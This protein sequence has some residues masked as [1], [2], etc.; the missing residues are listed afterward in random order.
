[1][2]E[3]NHYVPILKWKKGEQGAI[4]ELDPDIKNGLTPL[5]E[6][7]PIDWDYENEQPKRTIDEHLE[8]LLTVLKELWEQKEC[9]TL[10]CYG[11]TLLKE[12]LTVHTRYH[13]YQ[14]MPAVKGLKLCL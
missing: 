1:M 14:I 13:I 9:C 12:W 11:L 10:I 8:G 6:V 5:I 2:F 7:P 4:E 3:K